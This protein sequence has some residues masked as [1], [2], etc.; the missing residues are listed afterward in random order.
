MTSQEIIQKVWAFCHQYLGAEYHLYLFG[1]RAENKNR[2]YSD[3]DFFV[4]G[5]A[6]VPAPKWQ[7]F[8]EAVEEV[9]TLY[10]IDLV[11]FMRASNDF[12]TIAGKTAR[13]VVDGQVRS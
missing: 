2:P 12:K 4:K 3:F 1:S 10:K 9:D 6:A 5:P 11:D 13:E 7:R 8:C